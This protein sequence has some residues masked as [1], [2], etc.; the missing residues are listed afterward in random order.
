MTVQAIQ[1]ALDNGSSPATVLGNATQR[2]EIETKIDRIWA[3]AGIDIEFLPTVV[4]YNNTFA[5]QGSNGTG[6]R[7]QG[8]FSTI[9]SQAAAQGGILNASASVINMFFVNVV[10]GFGPL[11]AKTSAGLAN[12]GRNGIAAYVGASLLT[13]GKGTD[14]IA[15]VL[16]HEIGHNL[17]LKHTPPM[18]R[19]T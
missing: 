16:A 9:L 12:I 7:N 8:D 15:G 3:Q 10:P 17:G 13:F 14:V 4:R 11:S 19:P 5:Y 6:T 2:A 18:A 1:T